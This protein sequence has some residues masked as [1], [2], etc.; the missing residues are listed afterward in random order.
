MK[1]QL[2]FKLAFIIIIT[3]LIS[4]KSTKTTSAS[5]TPSTQ[6]KYFEGTVKYKFLMDNVTNLTDDEIAQKLLESQEVLG[7]H[8][9]Y[10][11]KGQNMKS[12]IDG[13][14][15]KVTSYSDG[16][17]SMYMY[18]PDEKSLMKVSTYDDWDF[19]Y[20]T[21]TKTENAKI[22]NNIEC[23]LLSF[24][25][26]K[27]T[28]NYYYNDKYKLNPEDHKHYQNCFW[29]KAIE[30]TGALPLRMDG[31]ISGSSMYLEAENIIEEKLDDSIFELP[32]LD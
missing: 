25:S 19:E 18:N 6:T 11:F 5:I 4:C 21:M 7:R 14:Y 3:T 13:P 2:G 23:D 32:I 9:T 26:E 15:F 12:I 31:K 30:E 29:N 24:K 22:I 17:D 1:Y 20:D 10:H 28:W 8:M 27:Y 16:T